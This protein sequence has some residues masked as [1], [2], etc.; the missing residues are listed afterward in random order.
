MNWSE[1]LTKALAKYHAEYGV[2]TPMPQGGKIAVVCDKGVMI[3]S[4]VDGEN[5]EEADEI[6]IEIIEKVYRVD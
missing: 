3:I 2:D 1:V 5:E 6:S 4:A